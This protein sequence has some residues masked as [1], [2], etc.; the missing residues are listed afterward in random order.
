MNK[1]NT[2]YEHLAYVQGVKSAIQF[3][4]CEYLHRC[5][6]DDIVNAVLAIPTYKSYSEWTPE[7]KETAKKA[8]YMLQRY[9]NLGT[10]F[11]HSRVT[12][13]KIF[14]IPNEPPKEPLSNSPEPTEPNNCAD[15]VKMHLQEL[16]A[17]R[18][19]EGNLKEKLEAFA[20]SMG[21]DWKGSTLLKALNSST[22]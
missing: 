20:K 14:V 15:F 3:I 5:P 1:D 18:S 2:N 7:Q 11:F 17:L 10:K 8:F 13:Q 16:N 9:Q 19:T 6:N 22:K 21:Y 12:N 4:L